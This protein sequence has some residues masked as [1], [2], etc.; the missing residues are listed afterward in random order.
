MKR[1]LHGFTVTACSWGWCGLCTIEGTG[2]RRPSL[3][4]V[5]KALDSKLDLVPQ[6][7]SAPHTGGRSAQL[8]SS[9][10]L[11]SLPVA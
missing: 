6:L 10:F 8:G 1:L 3:G 7:P 5:G 11:I 4:V 9:F 2:T